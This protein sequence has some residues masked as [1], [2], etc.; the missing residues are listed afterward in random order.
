MLVSTKTNSIQR[1][2]VYKLCETLGLVKW[3]GVLSS[4]H[5]IVHKKKCIN[6]NL[7]QLK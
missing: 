4:I 1:K 6:I 2:V 7:S 3:R 5:A